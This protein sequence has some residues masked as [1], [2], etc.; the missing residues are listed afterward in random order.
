MARIEFANTEL[1]TIAQNMSEGYVKNAKAISSGIA[2]DVEYE[3]GIPLVPTSIPMLI[4]FDSV[5]DNVLY[6]RLEPNSNNFL[7]KKSFAVIAKLLPKIIGLDSFPEGVILND[8]KLSVDADILL[9]D[10]DVK[11]EVKNAVMKDWKF[12]CEFS[13][14]GE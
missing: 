10:Y 4:E 11:A 5:A 14:V 8:G 3:H 12:V 13:L 9:S 2:F 1:A 6:F 7:I